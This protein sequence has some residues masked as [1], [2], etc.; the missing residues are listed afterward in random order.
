MWDHIKLKSFCPT[1]ETMDTMK[2]HTEKYKRSSL[3]KH[4]LDKGLFLKT[5]KSVILPAG[6]KTNKHKKK[7]DQNWG[8][9][10]RRYLC[11]EDR[12][13]TQHLQKCG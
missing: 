8:N 13:L 9:N 3:G 11:K 1:K 6:T 4:T 5:Y 12:K 7:P 10:L 2:K